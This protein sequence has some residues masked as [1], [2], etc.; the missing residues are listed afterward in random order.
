MLKQCPPAVPTERPTEVTRRRALKCV[1][2][3]P[4]LLLEIGD[5][6]FR[7]EIFEQLGAARRTRQARDA[8]VR[9]VQIAKYDGGR[10]T[11]L[12][13]GRLERAIHNAA[14]LRFGRGLRRLDALDAER[15]LLH[16]TDL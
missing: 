13:T 12:R 2:F 9:I 6:R 1:R 11:R 10:R 7:P 5:L 4:G 8:A 3:M 15:A 16:H 14:F